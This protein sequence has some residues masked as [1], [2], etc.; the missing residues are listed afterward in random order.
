M[1]LDTAPAPAAARPA[2]PRKR[3]LR[4]GRLGLHA[5]LMTVSLAFLAPL[6]LAVYASL[7]PYDETS[8]HGYFS[9]RRS[10][11]STTTSRPS[12]TRR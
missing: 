12:A 3:L 10:S 5:F 6:L 9:C 8:E 7:R 11:P 1:T 4:P 2:Q